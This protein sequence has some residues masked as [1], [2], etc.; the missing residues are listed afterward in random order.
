GCPVIKFWYFHHDHIGTIVVNKDV[1]ARGGK[2][3]IVKTNSGI[4]STKK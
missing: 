3:E 1:L 4:V 2:D